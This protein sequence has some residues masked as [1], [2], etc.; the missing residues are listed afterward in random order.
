MR[1]IELTDSDVY[2]FIE[3]VKM[4]MQMPRMR[5]I[6]QKT[7]VEAS[8]KTKREIHPE[9]M[10]RSV[11]EL[12][13]I[14]VYMVKSKIRKREIVDVRIIIWAILK[15]AYIELSDVQ[16]GKMLNRDHATVNHWKREFNNP[17]RSDL[18]ETYREMC[19]RLFEEKPKQITLTL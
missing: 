18:H 9:Y 7:R 5:E 4:L 13:G 10:I 11:C 19:L 1:E 8:D 16:I 3:A 17:H 14:P 12:T 2:D 6:I 15:K